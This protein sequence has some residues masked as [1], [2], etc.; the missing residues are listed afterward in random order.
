MT[1][2]RTRTC[3]LVTA[4]LAMA[5]RSDKPAADHATGDSAAPATPASAPSAPPLVHVK[6]ADFKFDMPASVPEG[7]V[8]FHLMNEGKE[9]HQAMV[10]RLEDGKTV[11][12]L[13]EAMKTEGPP[14]PWVKWL[15]GPNGIA[16]SATATSTL[17]LTPGHYAVM[18]LIPSTDGV[19][20]M[21][22]GMVQG[23]E[24][25]A[26]SSPAPLPVATDTVHLKDY[27]FESTRALSAGSHTILVVN[28]G[29]Q[30][31]EM[32]VLKLSPGKKVKDFADWATTGGMK[33]PPPAM[34]IG[35]AGVMDAGASSI[36][37]ADLTAGDYGYICFVPDAKDGKLHLAHGMLSQFTVQ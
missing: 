20:H 28:D 24:V 14:P 31:H 19:P 7:A 4:G 37:N 16:P 33:G 6:A 29:P 11:K 23:F 10:V 30:A 2:V 36:I 9:L 34:P 17:L 35:G 12:D 26:S 18:C 27:K 13:A 25:A 1:F 8:S 22:K 32:V 5:C 15:G 21:A 3:L